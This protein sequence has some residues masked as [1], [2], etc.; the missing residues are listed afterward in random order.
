[1]REVERVERRGGDG[2][3]NGIGM[4]DVTFIKNQ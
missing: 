4:Q 1:V 2:E 3:M